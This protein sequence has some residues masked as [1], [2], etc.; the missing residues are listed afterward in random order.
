MDVQCMSPS[1]STGTSGH[2]NF[3][4]PRQLE[5]ADINLGSQN[6]FSKQKLDATYCG[7]EIV[8]NILQK[9]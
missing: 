9:M 2:I 8:S 3:V 4:F 6:G 1:T 5:C 7:A